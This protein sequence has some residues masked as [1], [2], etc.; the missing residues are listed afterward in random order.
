MLGVPFE[1]VCQMF[2][3]L[4][5]GVTLL[6]KILIHTQTKN[7]GWLQADVCVHT[8][9]GNI[10]YGHSNVLGMAS[11]VLREMLKQARKHGHQ[12]SISMLGVPSEAV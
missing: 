2:L 9:N 11:P 1:A 7:K 6:K 8:E 5:F 4:G 10:N 12:R 3:I